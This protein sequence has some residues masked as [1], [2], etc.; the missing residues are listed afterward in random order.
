[1]SVALWRKY[2]SLDK[3][4]LYERSSLSAGMFLL[5][6]GMSQTCFQLMG[7]AL[8]ATNCKN[9]NANFHSRW[10]APPQYHM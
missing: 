7:L 2:D 3:K 4:C 6:R 8:T 9:D 5:P 10:R 1:M